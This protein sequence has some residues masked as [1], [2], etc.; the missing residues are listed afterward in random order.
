MFTENP[1]D[2]DIESLASECE[3]FLRYHPVKFPKL[4]ISR[5]TYTLGMILPIFIRRDKG[6]M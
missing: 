3:D 6:N 1:T 4:D 5:K 2:E